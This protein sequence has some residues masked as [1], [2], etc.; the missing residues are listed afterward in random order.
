MV[1]SICL[2]EGLYYSRLLPLVYFRPQYDLRCGILTLREKTVRTFP[3]IEI[4]L[5]CRGYLHDTLVQQN[6]GF[7]YTV[8]CLIHK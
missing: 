8:E 5:H 3:D 6:P 7:L 2:F 4:S 1:D